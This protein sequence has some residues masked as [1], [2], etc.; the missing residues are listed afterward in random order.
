MQ[1]LFDW[2]T[3]SPHFSGMF[4]AKWLIFSCLI[5][6]ALFALAAFRLVLMFLLE[7]D[8][9]YHPKPYNYKEKEI[10]EPPAHWTNW[11]KHY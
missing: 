9:T 10:W 5:T 6:G 1:Q 11:T 2:L 3:S 7:G 8:A 4:F